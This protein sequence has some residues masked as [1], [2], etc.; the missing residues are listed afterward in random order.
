MAQ[1]K[2]ENVPD[3]EV[4]AEVEA[5]LESQNEARRIREFLSKSPAMVQWREDVRQLCRQ[6]INENGIDNLTADK[7]FDLIAAKAREMIPQE[8]KEEVKQKL[9]QFLLQQFEDHI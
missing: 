5:V 2:W 1:I 6:E 3:S 8:I 7:L 4:R 9:V